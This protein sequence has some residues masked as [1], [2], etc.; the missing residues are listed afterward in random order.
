MN[1]YITCLGYYGSLVKNMP[2]ENKSLDIKDISGGAIA[3]I[4]SNS[5]L[6]ALS[7]ELSYAAI[8]ILPPAAANSA[9]GDE[10]SD[11]ERAYIVSNALFEIYSNAEELERDRQ[12]ISNS[13]LGVLLESQK[14]D[15]LGTIRFRLPQLFKRWKKIS[16]AHIDNYKSGESLMEIL[17]FLSFYTEATISDKEYVKILFSGG[18]YQ[19]ADS[20]GTIINDMSP[21]LPEFEGMVDEDILLSRLV[22][23]SPKSIDISEVTSEPLLT[24]LKKIFP[25]RLLY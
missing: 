23:I 8:S 16:L 9:V 19:L 20:D 12:L 6:C 15:L 11:D 2:L 13:L 14:V 10:F 5:E 17:D 21:N 18:K 1:Y 25:D 3:N 4:S 24:L 22:N 7:N